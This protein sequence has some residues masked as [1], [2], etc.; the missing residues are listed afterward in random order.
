M[1]NS[2][3]NKSFKESE[4]A[5]LRRGP[6]TLEEDT[7][8]TTYI[9]HNG[10]GRWNLAAKCAGLKRTGK[11][12]RLRWL[13][14]LKP[15]IRR[16]NLTPQEQLLILELHSK[17]GNRWSKIAQYLPGRTDNEIKNYWRTRVQKQARQLNIESNSDKFFDAV[18]SFWVPRL[19]EKMEQNSSTTYA[20]PQNNNNNNN[21]NSSLLPPSQT[22][23]SMSTQ[24]YQDLSGLSNMDGSSSSSAFMPDLMTVPHFMDPNT[25]ID[26]SMCYHEDNAQ[27]LSGYIL[28][29]EEYYYMENSDIST[30]C[31]VAEA[32]E[33]VTQDPMWNMDDIWQFRE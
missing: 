32:Y 27:E 21:N 19:I 4:E 33:N 6:W 16:G 25:I 31:Q 2:M 10:E 13:N 11:S 24:T 12:C 20:C 1:E 22:F 8:L 5:K 7:L 26:G 3:K 18:R 29:T 28:G 15:D 30:E 9:L 14:Y 23:E 17:W